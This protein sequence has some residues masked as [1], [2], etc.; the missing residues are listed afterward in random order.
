MG[1]AAAAAP[2][3]PHPTPLPFVAQVLAGWTAHRS[4]AGEVYYFNTVTEVEVWGGGHQPRR[5]GGGGAAFNTVSAVEGGCVLGSLQ[6]RGGEGGCGSQ[7]YAGGRVA[8][9]LR[10]GEARVAGEGG[11][12]GRAAMRRRRFGRQVL[13]SATTC[14]F[15]AGLGAHGIISRRRATWSVGEAITGAIRSLPAAPPRAWPTP[16]AAAA[17]CSTEHYQHHTRPPPL[18]LPI[19]H[20]SPCRPPARVPLP[21]QTCTPPARLLRGPYSPTRNRHPSRRTPP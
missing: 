19:P 4:E 13:P 3:K 9:V 16:Y 1:H 20:P 21:L 2:P 10:R 6:E 11:G 18:P 15:G 5:W 12:K 7:R 17:S 8:V 14:L